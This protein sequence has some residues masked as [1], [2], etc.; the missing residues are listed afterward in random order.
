MPEK[1]RRIRPK[2]R[3]PSSLT[4]RMFFLGLAFFVVVALALISNYLSPKESQ[5]VPGQ[6]TIKNRKTEAVF[7]A[8][9][10]CFLINSEGV[11]F[12]KSSRPSGNITF[13]FYDK[14]GR[15]AP[16][17]GQE[18]I[19]PQKLVE[20]FFIKKEALARL[21]LRI[22]SAE[23][24]DRNFS[25]FDLVSSEGWMLRVSVGNNANATLDILERT[26]AEIGSSRQNLDYIDLRLPTRVFY[27]LK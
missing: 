3:Q 2:K 7:C 11:A 10:A 5:K 22:N 8:E 6:D 23:I 16:N 19:D 4:K 12:K 13:L 24:T 20:I 1:V 15:V 25:D 21:D 26:L 17:V 9:T 27:K 14:T 18:V